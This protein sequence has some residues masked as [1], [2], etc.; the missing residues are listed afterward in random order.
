MNQIRTG[1]K[2]QQLA[3][4]V[5]Q[6]VFI[7][8]TGFRFPF[9]HFPSNTASGSE[10][11]LLF[12]KAVHMLS[13]FNFKVM[14]VSTD[15]AQSNRDFMHYLLPD[16]SSENPTTMAFR[17][18]FSSN[19]L[20]FFIMDFSHMM[21]KIRNNI[22]KSGEGNLSKRRL[23]HK[24]QYIEWDHFRKAYL[25]DI[26]NNPFPIHQKLTNE[27]LFLSN[28]GKMRNHLAE[29]VLNTEMLHLMKV[30]QQSLG[31]AG[32]AL[33]LTVELLEKTSALILTFRDSRPITDA[34]D[35]RLQEI[36][37]IFL[38]FVNWEKDNKLNTSIKNRE[39]SLISIQ[40]RE[41]IVSCLLG[42]EELCKYRLQKSSASIVPNR[43][44]SDLIENMFC[45]QRTLHN[46][47][48]TNPTYLGYCRS[49]N[50][51]ILGQTSVS[52]KS[53]SGGGSGAG[54]MSKATHVNKDSHS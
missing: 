25:W 47:A 26:S 9:A 53:N 36:H 40:T 37:D 42:F 48:N 3:T 2:E 35:D 19:E 28:E 41:D 43:T 14:F 51:V 23:Q 29:D 15:G 46:G 21:K 16:F 7:G 30:Y 1:R 10:L 18:I 17:N 6:F 20:I 50:A 31:D 11:Y 44:N 54:L 38:W 22:C 8:F 12:W 27:H 24:D 39:K 34:M 33:N 52:R 13:M 32:V 4:H 45:Q 5:L 49:V